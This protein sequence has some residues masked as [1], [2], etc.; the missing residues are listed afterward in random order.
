MVENLICIEYITTGLPDYL[1]EHE[2]R[3]VMSKLF[4]M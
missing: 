4:C 1:D 3:A 2:R